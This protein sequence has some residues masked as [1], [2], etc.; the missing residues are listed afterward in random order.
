MKFAI[1]TVLSCVRTERTLPAGSYTSAQ[2]VGQPHMLADEV[3]QAGGVSTATLGSVL[4][5]RKL[6]GEAGNLRSIPCDIATNSTV[7]AILLLP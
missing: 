3:K 7:L 2:A 4:L 1:G 5:D 6:S